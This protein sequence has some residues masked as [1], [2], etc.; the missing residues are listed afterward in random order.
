[1]PVGDGSIKIKL[2]DYGEVRG[3]NASWSNNMS[4]LL[5]AAKA[6][7]KELTGGGFRTAAEQIRLRGVNDCPDIY[8]APPSSCRVPTAIPGTSNHELGLA[9]DYKDMC[10]PNSTCAGNPRYDWL[11]ANA[12]KWKVK[13]LS[14]EAWHWSVDGK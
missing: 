12:S 1:M 7:G 11:V 8:T 9:I 5:A 10:F 14:S 13:K 2:C 3:V 4:Q 6:D